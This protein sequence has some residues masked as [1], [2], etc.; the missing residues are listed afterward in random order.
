MNLAHRIQWS[1]DQ[2]TTFNSD[3]FSISLKID[4]KVINS[5]EN[6]SFKWNF[7]KADWKNISKACDERISDNYISDNSENS[8]T[9]LTT[10]LIDNCNSV[11]SY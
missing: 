5:E 10:E 7:K 1:V 8:N 9:M 11:Y 3:H 4:I 2:N 6:N